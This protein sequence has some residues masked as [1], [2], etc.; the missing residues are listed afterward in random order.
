MCAIAIPF[1]VG[2]NVGIKVINPL[3]G[4]GTALIVICIG[5]LAVSRVRYIHA[6]KRK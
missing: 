3:V 6:G 5:T 4:I 2:V 1:V